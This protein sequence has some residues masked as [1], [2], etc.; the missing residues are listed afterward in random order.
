MVIQISLDTKHTNFVTSHCN[1]FLSNRNILHNLS[2]YSFQKIGTRWRSWLKHSAT[3]LNVA[4]SIPDVVIGIF[5]WH[6]PS[7]RAMALG[8]TQPLA[9]MNTRNISWGVKAAGAWSWQ[10]CHRHV[11]IVMKSGSLKLLEILGL[12]QACDGVAVPFA[13]CKTFLFVCWNERR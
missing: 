8:L 3:S 12:A 11:P 13:F 6:N 7:G 4:G 9:E 5:H 10:P 1:Y 2:Y